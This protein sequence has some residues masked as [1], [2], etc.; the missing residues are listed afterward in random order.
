MSEAASATTAMARRIA[1]LPFLDP[2]VVVVE[3]SAAE[4]RG[5]EGAGQCIDA[6]AV[7]EV[8]VGCDALDND[9]APL[10]ACE[11]LGL[12]RDLAALVAHDGARAVG[13]SEERQV[14][15][16]HL[17]ARLAVPGLARRHLVER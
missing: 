15:G 5:L 4:R 10:H 17:D 2:Y 3:G 9:D 6:F 12:K 14:V 7:L 16:M 11:R 13:D 8:R 1:H